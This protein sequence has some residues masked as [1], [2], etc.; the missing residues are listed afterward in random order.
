MI[1]KVLYFPKPAHFTCVW[2]STGDTRNPLMRLWV[3]HSSSS[4]K[5]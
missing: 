2:V 5:E 4:C 3:H 1:K